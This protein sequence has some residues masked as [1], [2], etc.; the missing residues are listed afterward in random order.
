MSAAPSLRELELEVAARE[1]VR[2]AEAL[3]LHFPPALGASISDLRKAIERL[4]K[5]RARAAKHA[6]KG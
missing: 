4:D 3:L 5:S 2:C 6:R 1:V